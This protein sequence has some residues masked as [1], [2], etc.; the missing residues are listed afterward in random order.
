MDNRSMRTS[1][2][3]FTTPSPTPQQDDDKTYLQLCNRISNRIKWIDDLIADLYTADTS[4][5]RVITSTSKRVRVLHD[6]AMTTQADLKQ[7][8][9]LILR[10]SGKDHTIRVNEYHQL[11]ALLQ[12]RLERVTRMLVGQGLDAPPPEE[13]RAVEEPGKMAESLNLTKSNEKA[14]N[15]QASLFIKINY[16]E[17]LE[18]PS[19]SQAYRNMQSDLEG[20][21]KLA[22]FFADEVHNAGED[23]SAIESNL[24]ETLLNATHAR[25][26]VERARQSQTRQRKHIA[27]LI[28]VPSLLLTGYLIINAAFQWL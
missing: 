2:D 17:A 9:L 24:R 28:A 5:T 14:L 6:V 20:I 23:L 13:M 26:H 27:L 8:Q 12:Q 18:S 3:I 7:L 11:S 4:S 19:P 25:E 16:D 1:D 10:S 21:Q 22:K 15:Q